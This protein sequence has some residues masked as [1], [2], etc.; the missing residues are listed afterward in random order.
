MIPNYTPQSVEVVGDEVKTVGQY[1]ITENNQARI[2]VSLS[3]K[4]YTRK[5]LAVIREYSN[6]GNDAH[7]EVGKSTS[8][9]IV[10]LPT[11]DDL[12]FKVRDF[13]SGLTKEQIRDVYCVLGESTKRNSN[14]QNGVLGYGCK[15][16]FAHSDSFTVT[17]WNNGEKTIYNCIKGDVSK[18]PSV[19]ELSRS[20]S[21]EPSGIEV[22][23]P[24]KHSSIWTFHSEAVFLF[25]YWN[26][27]PT[28][29]NLTEDDKKKLDGF[30]NTP[31]TIS[32]TNWNIRTKHEG[33]AGG[34]AF[35][36]GVPY[37]IDWN[38][39]NNKLATNFNNRLFF[40]LLQNNDVVL[41][42]EMGEV[43][44]VDSRE[45]LEYTEHTISVILT[46]VNEILDKIKDSFQEKFTILPNLWEAKIMYN[47]IFAS[48]K[49][50]INYQDETANNQ[51]KFLDGNIKQIGI[52]LS[53]TFKWN[54]IPLTSAS[55]PHVNRF[56][57]ANP[58]V[59]HDNTHSPVSPI[60][61]TYQKINDRVWRCKGPGYNN[62]IVAS[63]KVAIILNDTNSNKHGL[64]CKYYMEQTSVS[65]IHVLNFINDDIKE[66]FFKEYDFYSIPVIKL[67]DLIEDAKRWNRPTYKNKNTTSY[68][69]KKKRTIPYLDL[70]T[71]EVLL[72]DV[73]NIAP[74]SLFVCSDP[75]NKRITKLLLPSKNSLYPQN[76]TDTVNVLLS[77]IGS[78][79]NKIYILNNRMFTSKWAEKAFKNR[80]LINLYKYINDNIKTLVEDRYLDKAMDLYENRIVAKSIFNKMIPLI[81]DKSNSICSLYKK[82]TEIENYNLDSV[83][84]SLIILTLHKNVPVCSELA[85]MNSKIAKEYPYF[86]QTKNTM[87]N[88]EQ[89]A[90]YIN[91][92][93]LYV[94]IS[95][96]NAPP[97]DIQYETSINS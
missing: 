79:N 29:V 21:D 44:F 89:L 56:D 4:M 71:K 36:G 90:T 86:P 42:F 13:G 43:Q 70:L 60:T 37:R 82:Y 10:T 52:T 53:G 19:I 34:V 17:S 81:S 83:I 73:S 97:V 65:L 95:T 27:L 80:T 69:T 78:D 61:I 40:T 91:A 1:R 15:A 84:N 48:D 3:D 32:G 26:T 30:R 31:P 68:S 76:F 57:N 22:C 24:V 20:P 45:G 12:N 28:I 66:L 67:S 23:V 9:L 2:L 85:V 35:M 5:E 54:N 58:T 75:K 59:I 92:M 41:Y 46:R 11:Y 94:D 47:S 88:V 14:S 55:F 96:R 93:D 33:S 62:T 8:E 25:R 49:L 50:M 64:V 16:G 74:G 39:I 7:I 51:I 72:D 77:H 63:K 87:L 18:L 6:N 38:I